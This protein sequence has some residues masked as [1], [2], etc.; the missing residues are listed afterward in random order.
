M[1]ILNNKNEITRITSEITDWLAINPQQLQNENILSL[2]ADE[3]VL[4]L[5]TAISAV[6]ESSVST[7]RRFACHLDIN[8][9]AIPV[10]IE[11]STLPEESTVGNLIGTIRSDTQTGAAEGPGSQQIQLREFIELFNDPTVLFEMVDGEPIVRAVNSA[12]EDIFGYTSEFV[13]NESLDNYIVPV[14]HKPQARKLNKKVLNGE[15]ATK[16]VTRRTTVGAQEFAY[17]GLPIGP[18][19]HQR[20]DNMYGLGIYANISEEQRARQQLQVLHRVLRHNLRNELT[21][22]LGVAEKITTEAEMSEICELGERI[23]DRAEHLEGVS[24]KAHLAEKL[25]GDPPSNMVVDVGSIASEVASESRDTWPE[26]TITSDIETPLPV[27]TGREFK[28]VLENLVENAIKYNREDPTVHLTAHS[29]TPIH[30]S[31]REVGQN[32]IISVEDNGPGIPEHEREAIF[33]KEDITQLNH[34]SG[35]GLW[36]VRW[37]I[38]LSDGTVVHERDDGWTKIRISLPLAA[39]DTRV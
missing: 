11:L 29:Q 22:I 18:D 5:Q 30:A 8:N 28:D 25:L 15:T 14:R 27:S 34:G 39:E 17:R 23:I 6:Q 37:I 1:F 36:V 2:V 31:T 24:Q 10:K 9:R 12:F 4:V 35:L 21:V 38:E 26:A 3:D 7:S 20:D 16:V 19:T 32:A 13:V 33:G